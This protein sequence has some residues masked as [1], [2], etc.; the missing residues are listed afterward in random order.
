MEKNCIFLIHGYTAEISHMFLLGNKLK[1]PHEIQNF[2]ILEHINYEVYIASIHAHEG[3]TEEEFMQSTWDDWFASVEQQ[4]LQKQKEGFNLNLVGHSMGGAIALKLAQKYPQHVRSV[5]T[6]SSPLYLNRFYPADIS[7]IPLFFV[8]FFAPF[9]KKLET[10]F[11]EKKKDKDPQAPKSY[12]YLPQLASLVKAIAEIKKE[13]NY[14]VAPLLVLHAFEDTVVP[15]QNV[16]EIAKRSASS[17]KKVCIYTIQD[18]NAN[19]HLLNM[20]EET[21]DKVSAEILLFLFEANKQ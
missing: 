4:F 2:H 9:I 19:K 21:I 16:V 7:S 13:M 10:D 11:F 15:Y 3:A 14:V 18:E 1:N 17:F 5:T 12:H 8:P 20:H 6:I